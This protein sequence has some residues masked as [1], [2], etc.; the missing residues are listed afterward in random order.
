MSPSWLNVVSRSS[1][2]TCGKVGMFPRPIT[3]S[4]SETVILPSA[5]MAANRCSNWAISELACPPMVSKNDRNLPSTGPRLDITEVTLEKCTRPAVAPS[6]TTK[7]TV[8]DFT[9]PLAG[10]VHE[11]VRLARTQDESAA[12]GCSCLTTTSGSLVPSGANGV[13]HSRIGLDPAAADRP[14]H[15]ADAAMSMLWPGA[16]SNGSLTLMA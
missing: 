4:S 2:L 15:I 6:V 12:S 3:P 11:P 16:T 5:V 10:T 14:C 8:A 1:T 9:E 13:M 7:V